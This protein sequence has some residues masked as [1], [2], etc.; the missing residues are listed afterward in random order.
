MVN[1]IAELCQNHKGDLKILDEMVA[2]AAEAKADYVKI[3]SM[4]S[5]DLTFRDRFEK[6][7]IEG[8]RVRVI[9]R[10]YKQ[11]YNRLKKLDL[12]D[13]HHYKFLDICKKYKIKPMTSIFT[14]NRLNFLNSLKEIEILKV[15]SFDC[16]SYKLIEK[17]AKSRKKL[18]ISTGGTFD[19]EIAS[20]AK[21]LKKNKKKF[22]FLHCISIYPTPLIEANLARIEFLKK[23]TKNI[24][25]SD[26][27]N[28]DKDSHKLSIAAVNL[29]AK[30]IERHFT[31]L[32]KN[33]TR[34]GLVSVN[35]DQ[36]RELVKLAK[37]SKKNIKQYVLKE[38]P[39]YKKMIGSEHRE[40]SES[41]LLNRDYYQGRFSSKHKKK[42]IFNW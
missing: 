34:D 10:P 6:G 22:T 37:S 1:I 4:R 14:I 8:G 30:T 23:F 26:H 2:A 36:L 29:G 20:T 17:L 16:P 28:P 32:K 9:K 18:I 40:L 33:E 31:I 27:S 5:S 19:R 42:I 13:S 3:Q 21:I 12:D 38:I 11:E 35:F 7:L 41:E 15:P 39:E 25:I 24:G